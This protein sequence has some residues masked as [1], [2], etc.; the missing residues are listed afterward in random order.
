MNS[1]VDF[2]Q[3]NFNP[4]HFFNDQHQDIKDPYLN[5][6]NNLNSNSFDRPYVLDKNIKRYLCDI[7]KYE[8]YNILLMS[9]SGV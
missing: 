9:I 5:Y 4:F 8:K 1:L 2:E 6:F 7:K 3:I